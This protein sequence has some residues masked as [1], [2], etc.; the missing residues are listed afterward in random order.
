L[1]EGFSGLLEFQSLLHREKITA[2]LCAIVISFGLVLVIARANESSRK[3]SLPT[4]KTLTVPLP[5]FIARTNS[6]PA[7][8]GLSRDGR[9]AAL[10][11]QGYGREQSGVRQSIAILDLSNNPLRDFPDHR[12][13][14][15]EKSTRQSY[16]IGLGSLTDGKHLYASMGSAAEN[17]IAIYKFTDGEVAPERFTAIPAQQTARG[18]T[19]TLEVAPRSKSKQQSQRN[20]TAQFPPH[21]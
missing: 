2:I 3:I 13:R 16:F 15:D 14:G 10:L 20:R 18:K 12:L 6:Y 8:I 7:P 19:V 11:N 1:Y 21:S 17:G 9:Y 5:G 4:S